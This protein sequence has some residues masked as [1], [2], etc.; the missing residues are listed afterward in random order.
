MLKIKSLI[1]VTAAVLQLLSTIPTVVLSSCNYSP[2]GFP[3]L[4]ARQAI[5]PI[6]FASLKGSPNSLNMV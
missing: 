5:S 4:A 2:M 1:V 6:L 3:S